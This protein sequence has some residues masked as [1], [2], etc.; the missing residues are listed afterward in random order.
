VIRRLHHVAILT[1]DIEGTVSHYVAMLQVQRPLITDVDR[2][3]LQLRTAMV[4]TGPDATTYIQI[5][6]PRRGAGVKELAERGNG[7]LFEIA[8]EVDDLARLTA[9]MR[10]QGVAPLDFAGQP[11]DGPFATAASGNRFAYLPLGTTRGTRTELI[12][13]MTVPGSASEGGGEA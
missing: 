1:D 2:P 13:P 8:F 6:E 12:E 4:P 10:D 7:S 11:L 9:T 5:I 3:D